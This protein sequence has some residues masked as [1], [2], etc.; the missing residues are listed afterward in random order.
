M[1][2][3]I[4]RPLKNKW[5]YHFILPSTSI[6]V[7]LIFTI[8]KVGNTHLIVDLI[9]S[10]L[11]NVMLSL[12]HV[13]LDHSYIFFSQVSI[14]VFISVCLPFGCRVSFSRYIVTNISPQSVVY[15][16]ISLIFLNDEQMF[17]V[18]MRSNLPF[19]L[20]LLYGNCF[21]CFSKKSLTN[22]R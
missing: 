7:S 21:S 19:L 11:M 22:P 2:K 13:L 1:F 16:L 17:L 12:F 9:C 15:L 20:L 5:L 10:F 3:E 14:W 4:I 6:T 18:L 8:L